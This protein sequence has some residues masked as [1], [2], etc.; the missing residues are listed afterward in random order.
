M[1]I[2]LERDLKECLAEIKNSSINNVVLTGG[3]PSLVSDLNQYVSYFKDKHVSILTNGLEQIQELP[4]NCTFIIS[5]DGDN[6]VMMTQRGV[7]EEH[8]L[9]IMDNIKFYR[10]NRKRI[11]I[12]VVITKYNVD[13]FSMW[14]MKNSWLSHCEITLILV[15]EIVDNNI[16]LEQKEMRKISYEIQKIL[17]HYNYHI[18]LCCNMIN[19]RD[20]LDLYSL[21]Y[22]ILFSPEFSVPQRRYEYFDEIF[23]TLADL[24]KKYIELSRTMQLKIEAY[25]KEKDEDF[26]FDPYSLAEKLTMTI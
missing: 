16:C 7:D 11:G 24:E 12:S 4:E 10:G 2:T 23:Y 6:G 18:Q 20:F 26:L 25:L 8:Y 5:L 3:E 17:E 14:I 1:P 15:S 9:K 22:P 19:K 13:L 21:E